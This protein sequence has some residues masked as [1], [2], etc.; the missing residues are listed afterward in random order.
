MVV[1]GATGCPLDHIIVVSTL[2]DEMEKDPVSQHEDGSILDN[3]AYP[4]VKGA[5]DMVGLNRVS[6]L[7]K[8]LGKDKHAGETTEKVPAEKPAKTTNELPQGVKSPVGSE[9]NKLQP[10]RTGSKI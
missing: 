10:S 1:H 8:E 6:N 3:P 4:D 9:K 7:L 2:E 5:Q